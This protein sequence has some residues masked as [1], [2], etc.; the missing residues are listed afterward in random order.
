MADD[1]PKIM[2]SQFCDLAFI[3]YKERKWGK[4]YNCGTF[5][6][7]QNFG[8]T[9][10]PAGLQEAIQNNRIEYSNSKKIPNIYNFQRKSPIIK[11]YGSKTLDKSF[12]F[13]GALIYHPT[14]RMCISYAPNNFDAVNPDII[15]KLFTHFFV[16]EEYDIDVTQDKLTTNLMRDFSREINGG[17]YTDYYSNR[18]KEHFGWNGNPNVDSLFRGIL[19]KTLTQFIN[20]ASSLETTKRFNPFNVINKYN[21]GDK[22]IAE[23]GIPFIIAG[24]YNDQNKKIDL[25]PNIPVYHFLLKDRAA[26]NNEHNRIA[27]IEAARMARER[28]LIASVVAI[29]TNEKERVAREE[30]ERV[31]RVQQ[32]AR[33]ADEA[34]RVAREEVNKKTVV[35]SIV[36]INSERERLEA[37]RIEAARI[38][39]EAEAAR[40]EVERIEAE[41]LEAERIEAERVAREEANNKAVVASIVAINSEEETRKQRV[42]E[43]A[44]RN[45]REAEA[46]RLEAA[47]IA[48]EAEAARVAREE[49]NKKAVVASIV[50][51]N[52]EE[53]ARAEVLRLAREVELEGARLEAARV[54]REEEERVAREEAERVAREEEERVAREEEANKKAVVASIVAINSEEEA[55]K[56]HI[57]EA[58]ERD[59][60]EAEEERI[61]REQ[62]RQE[63]AAS[64]ELK[65]KQ[66][67]IAASIISIISEAKNN[68]TRLAEAEKKRLE[69]AET[70][71]KKQEEAEAEAEKKRQEEEK[72]RQEEVEAEKKRQE[73]EKK[74]QEEVEAEKK[75]LEEEKNRQEE[76]EAET[77]RLEDEKKR[78]EDEKKRLEEAEKKRLEEAEKKIQAEAEKKRLE[79]E[80]KIKAEGKFDN[81]QITFLNEANRISK[82]TISDNQTKIDNNK[83]KIIKIENEII[84]IENEQKSHNENLVSAKEELEA[85]KDKLET[86]KEEL[87]NLTDKTTKT[88]DDNAKIKKIEDKITTLTKELEKPSG[89]VNS[90]KNIISNLTNQLNNAKKKKETIDDE[91]R[92]YENKNVILNSEIVKETID[93]RNQIID[94]LKKGNI[95]NINTTGKNVEI[96]SDQ[97]DS[98]IKGLFEVYLPNIN[99]QGKSVPE[100]A[101]ALYNLIP[102]AQKLANVASNNN[103][104]PKMSKNV[105]KNNTRKVDRSPLTNN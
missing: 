105:A 19:T 28:A 78:L 44:T 11:D 49:T 101:N 74:R 82:Q 67:A 22:I 24:Y 23:M 84:K 5:G 32:A 33:D 90:S 63:E 7:N 87:K 14:L 86:A 21:T 55:R 27:Q 6:R 64:A 57:K 60:R 26:Y 10:R 46:A 100:L 39:R 29:N 92:K 104:T 79:E 98:V 47:R 3:E 65:K 12:W 43:E 68:A 81:Y 69:E 48:R 88:I 58:S 42:R 97:D 54:A 95:E 99:I 94:I 71:T 62:Q 36:A 41:R 96:E 72:K 50:A 56:Q 18:V 16:E 66:N 76:V 75:R 91:N 45:A 2:Y 80:K 31:A 1:P 89:N 9:K 83:K 4:K 13:V 35:A 53:A 40:L 102:A 15:P 51:I 61:A 77:K 25:Y 8:I 52:S 103:N 59:A 17:F 38:A 73:E 70:E 20:E 30:A 37:A 34:E 85:V 93:I